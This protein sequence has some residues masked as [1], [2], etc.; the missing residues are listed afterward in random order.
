[1]ISAPAVL[2]W[3]GTST[4]S[5]IERIAA[6]MLAGRFG[7]LQTLSAVINVLTALGVQKAALR[8]VMRWAG[9]YWLAPE[10]SGRL[11]TA[12]DNLQTKPDGGV[13]AINGKCVPKYTAKMIVYK[14][15]P[16]RFNYLIADFESGTHKVDAEYYTAAI[17]KWLRKRDQ[18]LP[19]EEQ[20]G[21]SDDDDELMTELKQRRPF[22]FVPIKTPDESTLQTL[23]ARFP[24]VVFLLWTGPELEPVG[25]A[26]LP[27]IPLEPAVD[28]TRETDEYTHW[29]DALG[30][31]GG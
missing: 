17:C 26:Q 7:A 29:L 1:M 19:Y 9:P 21:Y 10:V 11:A 28:S 16:F 13:A 25:Y 12:F 14:T 24:T 18:K 8:N 30:A 4:A 2:A 15:Y 5:G 27:V 22:L 31:L 20:V 23:R 6:R 3:L